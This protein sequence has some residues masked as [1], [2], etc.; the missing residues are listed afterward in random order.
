MARTP[1]TDVP[2]S[3]LAGRRRLCAAADISPSGFA[4][5]VIRT[6][7][8]L[9]FATAPALADLMNL[10]HV[11]DLHR[12]GCDSC[13]IQCNASSCFQS[14]RKR[15]RVDPVVHIEIA[16][17]I[18][19]VQQEL[20]LGCQPGRLHGT[21]RGRQPVVLGSSKR[22]RDLGARIARIIERAQWRCLGR[23]VTCP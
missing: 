19:P 15:R 17:D 10:K 7:V 1:Q 12:T 23:I 2:I 13:S 22:A 9:G 18:A 8:A 20:L 21:E 4:R 16:P 14:F 3:T 5:L 11:F 6:V